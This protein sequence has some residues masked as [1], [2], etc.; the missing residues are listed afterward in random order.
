MAAFLQFTTDRGLIVEAYAGTGSLDEQFLRS[1]EHAAKVRDYLIKKF[2]ISPG[3]IGIMP[4]GAV[5]GY[6]DG[7]ALVLLKK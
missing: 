2:S 3:H 7:I 5:P 6:E 1:R 4:M